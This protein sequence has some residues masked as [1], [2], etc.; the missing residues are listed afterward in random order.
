MGSK[1]SK[2]V[3]HETTRQIPPQPEQKQPAPDLLS[4][5]GIETINT[6]IAIDFS[7]ANQYQGLDTFGGRSLHFVS[8]NKAAEIR[9]VS[10]LLDSRF[11]SLSPREDLST[12]VESPASGVV[13]QDVNP[14]QSTI[15]ELNQLLANYNTNGWIPVCLFSPFTVKE[16]SKSVRGSYGFSEVNFSYEQAL[17][18]EPLGQKRF[19]SPVINWAVSKIIDRREFHMLVIL[20]CGLPDDAIDTHRALFDALPRRL[21]V[22]VIALG[23]GTDKKYDYWGQ[24][25]YEFPDRYHSNLT[26]V[27][28]RDLASIS[29][30]VAKAVYEYLL[31]DQLS[32][33]I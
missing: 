32:K 12:V 3:N 31:P 20:T 7:K 18:K 14:Y 2:L 25:K 4:K 16:I 29:G 27:Y 15:Q 9:R 19:F 33:K 11:K 30:E 26:V 24:F 1:K 21:L 8:K 5:I 6:M 23:D 28:A 13:D 17:L 22:V 10:V